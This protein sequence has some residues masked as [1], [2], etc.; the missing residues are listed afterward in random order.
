MNESAVRADASSPVA[1]L[2]A[3]HAATVAERP[4]GGGRFQTFR[5]L[6]YRD[7]R[8]LWIGTLFASSAQWV[9]QITVGW[10]A[11]QL[12]GSA[13]MLGAV[14]GVRALPLLVLAPFGGVAADRFERK[15]LMLWTQVLL[16]VAS[17]VMAGVILAG[18]VRVWHLIIYMM[19][20]G[21]AWAFNNPVRQAIVPNLVPRHD[22][23]NALALNSVGFNVTRIVGPTIA[24]LLIAWL[25]AGENFLIQA[26]AYA[27]MALMVVPMT[28]PAVKRATG[29]SVRESLSDGASYVW[30]SPI[31]R[32]MLLLA[33]VP[34]V[35]ALPYMALMPIFAQEVLDSGAGGYGLLM[36][37]GG[38]G[39]VVGTLTLASFNSVSRKG[40]IV[41]G[42]IFVLGL[43][44]MLFALSRSFELSL[45]LMVVAGA[46]QMVYMTTNQTILQLIVPD[47][48]R[49]R[50]MGIYMLNMGFVPFGSLMAGGLADLTSAPTAVL[51]MGL[52]TCLMAAGFAAFSKD[53]RAA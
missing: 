37:A 38:I 22:L 23:M 4:P 18:M 6:R 28:V 26:V 33:L 41:L 17:V 39:A 19:I 46:A 3:G 5:S 21:V 42:G 9:Q 2:A 32:T 44:L 52:S 30:G 7:Y 45:L 51:I 50:V 16:L 14:N 49:G 36:S 48:F 27:G 31:L 53:M 12:T 34:M 47:E 43:S 15:A 40:P 24:G 1:E 8:L 11:Y 35:L 29:V 25:G 13:T 20:T 10:L